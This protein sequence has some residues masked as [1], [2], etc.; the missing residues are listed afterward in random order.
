MAK[1]TTGSTLGITKQQMLALQLIA[2]GLSTREVA[3]M[4]FDTRDDENLAVDDEKKIQKGMEKVRRWLRD[5]KVQ[6]AYKEVLKEFMFPVVASATKRIAK[7]VDDPNGWLA[8]KAANDVLS[9]FMP[10]ILGEDS[11]QIVVKVE[12]MPELGAPTLE[13]PTTEDNG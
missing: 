6:S 5:P 1:Y 7:Q 9:R 13:G 11:K 4:V 3:R 2:D 10:E 12:G 8:N